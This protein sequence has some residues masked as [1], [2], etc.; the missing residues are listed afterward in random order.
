MGTSG[1]ERLR[2]ESNGKVGINSTSPEKQLTIRSGSGDDGGILI[3]P[4]VSYANNQDRAYLIVA[5]DSFGLGGNNWNDYG[6]QH[7]IKS[8][9]SGVSRITIDTSGGEAFC[10]ENGGN[11]GIGTNDPVRP[12]HILSLIHI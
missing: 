2:I 10:V 11:I 7:R 8:N 12:L 6:F 4:N 1:S 3:K 9:S 5:T